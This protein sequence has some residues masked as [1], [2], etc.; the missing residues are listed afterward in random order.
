MRASQVLLYSFVLVISNTLQAQQAIPLKAEEIFSGIKA[1]QIGPALMSG[2]ISDLEI[3][4]SNSK[5]IYVGTAGGGVWQS[6]NG[7]VA[8]NP[9]FDKHCQSIGCVRLDPSQPGKVIW[10][11]TGET[12]TRNSVSVGDGI[13]KST[14]GGQNWQHMG[15]S[16]SE[17][18]SDIVIH[19]KNSDVVY[20]GVLG[21]LWSDSDE[22]GVYKSVDG[23]KTWE[24]ILYINAQTGCSELVMDPSNPDILY[25]CFWQFRRTAYSFESGGEH[26]ALYKSKD[27]GK[28]WEKIH[29]G[30]PTGKLGRIALAVSP[31]LPSRLYAVLETEKDTDKGLYR[32][33]DG[34]NSW[35]H[36][37]GDFELVVRPFYFSRLVVDPKNPDIVLKAG[38]SGSIS[39]DGGATF[40]SIGGGMHS[41][42]HDFAFDP[43]DSQRLYAGTDGG[44]YRSWDGGT[45][46]EMVK[47]L[48]VSQFYHVSTDNQIPYKVYGGLQDNGSWTGPSQKP[49][50]IENRDWTSVGYGDGFRVYPHP[51]DPTI[52]YSEM[53]GAEQMWRVDLARNAYKIIKPYAEKGDPDLRFN[54]NAPLSTSLHNPD[55]VYVGSQFV[56][57]SDDRGES[58]RKL[59]PDLTTNDPAK[60][61]Q[62]KSGGLSVDNSGAENHCTIFTINES[63]KDKNTIWVGT[64]DGQIQ[65]TIDGGTSWRNVTPPAGLV[66]ANTWVHF[67]EASA[68]DVNTAFAV[69]DGHTKG[70]IKPYVL[71]TTDKGQTW[72]SISTAQIA[73]FARCIR[74]DHVNPNVL[75]LG[76]EAGLY[77]TVDGGINWVRF[78]NNLP[79]VA[80]HYL[81]AQ[82]QA[83]ALVLATHGRGIVIIDELGPIRSITQ[84]LLAQELAFIP[85]SPTVIYEKS[86]F[87][88]YSSPGEYVGQN[89]STAAM[90]TYFLNK[91]HT[92]GKMTLEV[93]D[94]LGKKVAD[95][96]PGKAKGLNVVE[97]NYSR[98]APKIAKA[99]TFAMS[100]FSTTDLPAGTYTVKITKGSKEFTHPIVLT[101]DPA[102][103]HS[104]ADR[105]SKQEIINQLYDMSEHLAW[106][107]DRL[108]S[109]ESGLKRMEKAI[110]N[111]K[112]RRKIAVESRLDKVY[113]LRKKMV[114]TT[115][116]NYVGTAEPELRE[117]ISS[118]YGEIA[119]YAGK[120]SQAQ[121]ANLS[122]LQQQLATV[123]SDMQTLIDDTAN[124][125]QKHGGKDTSNTTIQFRS[126]EDFLTADK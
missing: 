94:S 52:V 117:K 42:L 67:I 97:W 60:Q 90:I 107:V 10:V 91:R 54:W 110:A 29:A 57:V 92:L 20:T 37:S 11:G 51:A 62:E 75:Y 48:P 25:A 31:S 87:G 66:P 89:P 96:P 113:N 36:T 13:Y 59:S 126:K 53:Q 79:P 85:A 50:G 19:P 35:K 46:W 118:L 39:K 26:S 100:A 40:R 56:H 95:L 105:K 49:G 3:H 120:P 41:D 30:F 7:G 101:Y 123:A 103:I 76:T 63:P 9:I 64:D 4:P 14:D 34:G 21:K 73:S 71:K 22:R 74:Q 78:E 1:R 114:V 33:D 72:Q 32:S 70:D 93:F 77:I 116:D 119:G 122:E 84:D 23:G 99:K 112:I 28:T 5:V 80:I 115:G 8:F 125:I 88:S 69:F 55:R 83:D 68:H 24:K 104:A 6:S 61:Q 65:L 108:D 15:L 38:L 102:S 47:G 16:Q 2:R 43:S 44:V 12:W 106:E 45:V 121:L 124:A 109:L 111:Q 18:I 17:R 98:K 27:G 58:W 86:G 82:K 81:T